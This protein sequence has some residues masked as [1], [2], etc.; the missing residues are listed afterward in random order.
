MLTFKCSRQN[1]F[2]LIELISVVVILALISGLGATFIVKSVDSYTDLQERT[3]MV[4]HSRVVVEQMTRQLRTALPNGVRVSTSGNCIE[5]LPVVAA[6][7]YI[8]EVPDPENGASATSSVSVISMTINSSSPEH[9]IIAPYASTEVYTSADPAARVDLGTLGSSPYT[10]IP[11]GSSHQ[12]LRNSVDKRIFITEDPRRF[13]LS[14]SNLYKYYGYGLSTATLG[15]T[16]PGGS[17]AIMANAVSTAST[18]FALSS[19][20]E[21]RNA[22]IDINLSFTQGSQTLA[23]THT[24]FIRNVP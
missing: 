1:G 15:D 7:N 4:Q 13:C 24:V 11:L 23:V 10:S 12:F 8:G 2:T 22:T 6:S 17:S 20:S 3:N 16:D 21:D 18:A 5:F 9:V 19:G 14:G